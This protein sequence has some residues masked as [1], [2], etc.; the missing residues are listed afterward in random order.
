MPRSKEKAVNP[1]P[2]QMK[3]DS[4]KRKYLSQTDVPRITLNEALRIPFA[5]Y[6]NYG[7]NPT[8]PIKIAQVLELTP[9]SGHFRSIAGAAIAYGLT[10]GGPNATQIGIT[11]LGFRVVKPLAEDD[12]FHAK[13]ESFLK[14]QVIY[15]S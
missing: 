7:G 1:T 13:R 5:I 6:E 11:P 12:D 15:V 10:D 3:E 4:R 2:V 9:S 14:P 8:T